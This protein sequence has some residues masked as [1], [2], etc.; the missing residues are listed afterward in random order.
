MATMIVRNTVSDFERWR[1]AFEQHASVR[2]EYGITSA[3]IHR[4]VD[5]PNEVVVILKASDIGRAKEFASSESLRDAMQEAGVTGVPTM[6]FT[7]DVS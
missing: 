6:W 5:D 3:T 4:D 1:T 2:R 7:E